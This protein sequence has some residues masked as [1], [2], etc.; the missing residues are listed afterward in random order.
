MKAMSR[1]NRGS[2]Y[3]VFMVLFPF[4]LSLNMNKVI[5]V[6]RSLMDQV[7]SLSQ[8]DGPPLFRSQVGWFESFARSQ[9]TR[10]GGA[11][12]WKQNQLDGQREA[13]LSPKKS[14][15]LWSSQWLQSVR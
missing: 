8:M 7:I 11:V 4:K 5:L 2:N 12:R 6:V 14:S 1:E 10:Q 13:Y 15:R 3:F 9:S